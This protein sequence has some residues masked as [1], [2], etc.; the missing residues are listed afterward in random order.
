LRSWLARPVEHL[1]DLRSELLLKLTLAELCSVD[2]TEM[3]A[4][5]HD[6]VETMVSVLSSRCADSTDLVALWRVESSH[7]ALR[8]L[9]HLLPDQ[10]GR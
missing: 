7:A 8:F 4:A 2:T 10:D 3:L 1:R 9:A 6:H 5:Q